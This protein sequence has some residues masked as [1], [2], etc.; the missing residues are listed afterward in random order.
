[1]D[2]EASIKVRSVWSTG[3]LQFNYFNRFR[4]TPR[5]TI[6]AKIQY[7][8]IIPEGLFFAAEAIKFKFP[9]HGRSVYLYFFTFYFL[10]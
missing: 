5:E 10:D 7:S 4:N 8:K 9:F 3:P 1:M 2:D 6:D